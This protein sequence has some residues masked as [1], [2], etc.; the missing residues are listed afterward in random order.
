MNVLDFDNH[1]YGRAPILETLKKRLL[2]IKDGYRQNVALLGSRHIG[3]TSILKK[4][5]RDHED[6]QTILIYLD[7]EGRDFNHFTQLLSKSV[8]YH[9]Q[10]SRN[11]PVHEDLKILCAACQ[12]SIPQ[13][14]GLIEAVGGLMQDNKYL[15]AYHAL[16]SVPEIFA[17]ESGVALA[18]IL[19]EFQS[20]EQWDIPEVFSHLGKRIMTQKNVLYIASSSY[21]VYA[22]SILTEKLSLL[23]GNFEVI[24]VNSFDFSNSVQFLDVN[25]SSIKTGLHLK[26]FLADF[27]GGHPL[28]INILSQ[29]LIALAGVHRQEEAYAPL[30]VQAIENCVFN[31]WGVLSRH[32]E[33]VV[34][35]LNRGKSSQGVVS[36]VLIGLA[37][38]NHKISE[39]VAVTQ[40]KQAQVQQRL[41]ILMEAAIVEK[42]GSYYHLQDKLFKYWIQY[43]FER[44][45][46]AVDLEPGR[47]R[48]VFK[49]ELT[50][51][52]AEFQSVAR[53]DLTSRVSE[54]MHKFDN[55]AFELNGRRYKLSMFSDVTPVKLRLGAGSFGDALM[56]QGQEGSWL[57]VLKKDPVLEGD[58][59]ALVSA[60][61]DL[62]QKPSRCVVVSLSGLDETA[63]IRALQEKFWIWNEEDI[64]AL[65][66]LYDEPYLI[67]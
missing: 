51:A 6:A 44:R 37:Q 38:G 64:N 39:L 46:K 42:N 65:M 53:K 40:L 21:P 2:G 23:F 28:Y 35:T 15:E 59:N 47:Q 22:Q 67:R 7:L 4:L 57:I 1:F 49:E 20:M 48:K 13:T 11:Q 12:P 8:L 45:M 60:I 29:E 52:V 30:V 26:N 14:V 10:K 61:K 17:H 19:D 24:P 33:L 66:H 56:A 27:T 62:P 50:K 34:H 43:V 9:Y 55:E 41:N 5:V 32:F 58:M 3:K 36:S 25:L 31:P 16:L 54:L 63:K 18:L